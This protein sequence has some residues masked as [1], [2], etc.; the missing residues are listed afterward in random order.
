MKKQPLILKQIQGNE[1]HYEFDEPDKGDAML[2]ESGETVLLA[3]PGSELINTHNTVIRVNCI[4]NTEFYDENNNEER[5]F[6]N[7]QC[8]RVP[9]SKL[10]RE[11]Q[12]ADDKSAFVVGFE[13]GEEFVKTIDICFDESTNSAL[14]AKH[15]ITPN[16]TG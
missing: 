13:V 1:K 11:G 2:F 6:E 4:G 3:C 10:K 15:K 8:D 7:F 14:Y 5:S 16:I 12:C 9:R